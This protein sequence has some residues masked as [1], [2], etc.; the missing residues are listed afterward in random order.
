MNRT[1][2]SLE[3]GMLRRLK[4]EAARK[5]KT[6]KDVLNEFLRLGLEAGLH[7]GQGR[8]GWHLPVFSLGKPLLDAADRQTFHNLDRH[9]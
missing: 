5:G 1:T 7:R 9:P 4:E 3:A 2:V 8:K 6:L